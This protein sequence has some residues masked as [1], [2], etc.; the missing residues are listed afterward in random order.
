MRIINWILLFPLVLIAI[1]FAVSNRGATELTLWPFPFSIEMPLVLFG[2]IMMLIGFL[3][4]GFASWV[5]GQNKRKEARDTRKKANA[6]DKEVQSL[7]SELKTEISEAVLPVP[8]DTEKLPTNSK[9]SAS[10]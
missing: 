5:A 4:G 8:S 10:S 6:L 2:F 1:S 3:A 7:R 9:W